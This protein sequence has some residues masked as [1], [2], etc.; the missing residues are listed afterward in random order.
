MIQRFASISSHILFFSLLTSSLLG[1]EDSIS[2]KSLLHDDFALMVHNNNIFLSVGDNALE[3]LETM[4]GIIVLADDHDV[5]VNALLLIDH[6]EKGHVIISQEAVFDALEEALD[7]LERHY[8][9]VDPQDLMRWIEILATLEDSLGF[10]GVED[11]NWVEKNG[12]ITRSCCG[13][14]SKKF[15]NIIAQN[16]HIR[17]LTITGNETIGGSLVVTGDLTVEGDSTLTSLTV[18]GDVDIEGTLTVDGVPF[19]NAFVQNGNS[20]GTNGL[21]GTND[22]FGLNLE[23]NGVQRLQI[24]NAG[25][26]AIPNL[27]TVGIVHNDA[28]GLLTTSLIV[29]ADVDPAAA[30]VDTKLAT[31]STAGKVLNSA[32]TATSANTANAIVARDAS[33]NFTAGTVTASLTGA[34]SLN[35]LKTGDTMTGALQVPAGSAAL[36]SLRFTGSTTAGLSAAVA[37][38]LVLSTAALQR[39]SISPAGAVAINT[40]TS[41]SALTVNNN[42]TGNVQP[43]F[44]G[45]TQAVTTGST[46]TVNS[47]TMRMIW[48]QISA[49]AVVTSQSGGITSVVSGG[50]GVFTITYNTFTNSPVV[51]VTPNSTGLDTASAVV[52]AGPG[53]SVVTVTTS[54]SAGVPSD[55]PF[56]ILIIGLDS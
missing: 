48:A 21:L 32:T 11:G 47:G 1:A 51:L 33:G 16:A 19:A 25:T 14:S 6:L 4:R 43:L 24:S 50:V 46:G 3:L 39:I 5:V 36:P 29:N 31:I 8:D 10:E 13:G 22:S 7:I 49:G 23:T 2:A 42:G 44:V 54:S 35:V 28:S 12:V 34:A 27:S 37:D 38:T 40:P 30:I 45:G 15:C 55:E 52:T 53:A 20:F 17:S 41:G 18:T 26:V 9:A 56:G